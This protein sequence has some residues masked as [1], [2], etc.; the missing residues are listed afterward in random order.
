MRE[1]NSPDSQESK[2]SRP[3]AP[4][5]QG[6]FSSD[7]V[8]QRAQEVIDRHKKPE[9]VEEEEEDQGFTPDPKP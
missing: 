5:K 2:T 9:L 3:E 6:H 7:R 4:Q 8:A 1:K